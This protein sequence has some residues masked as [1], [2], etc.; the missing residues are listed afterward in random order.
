M[1][2]RNQSTKYAQTLPLSAFIICKNEASCLKNCILTLSQCHQIVI[3]DSGSTDGTL[4]II[5]EFKDAGWPIK[6]YEN[7]WPG[8][9]EQKQFALS[10]CTQDWVINLDADERLDD[11]FRD[12]LASLIKD[13]PD[14]AAWRIKRRPYLIGYGYAPQYAN[15][16]Y[17][18]RLVRRNTAHYDLSLK[19]H[20][21]MVI[22]GK[23]MIAPRGSILHL[24]LLFLD[25]QLKKEVGYSNLKVQQLLSRG[26][27]FS[28]IKMIFNPLVYFVRIYF[29]RRMFLCGLAGFITSITGSIYSFVTEVKLYQVNKITPPVDESKDLTL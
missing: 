28:L 27:R 8:F 11:E 4:E 18:L 5:K 17:M 3:V 13:Y 23:T 19:V 10:Q 15:E 12:S 7:A 2:H 20:E 25:E 22:K 9:S 16:G 29:L 14:V 6:F 1:N 21:A 26:K 24:R